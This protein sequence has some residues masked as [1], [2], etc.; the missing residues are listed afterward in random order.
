[1]TI[2]S[3]LEAAR[4][5]FD[6]GNYSDA[7]YRYEKIIAER[8][9]LAD[10]YQFNLRCARARS[11]IA[12]A[13]ATS[14]H[15]EPHR[16]HAS[17]VTLKDLYHQ[18]D[19]AAYS[20][21]RVEAA[22]V[23]LVSVLMTAHNVA[24]YI[25]DAVISVLR[26]SWPSLEVI[27]VDDASTDATWHVLQRLCEQEMRLKCVRL[28]TNLG[29]YFAKNL[30]L[31]ESSGRY[32]FFQDGDDLS[33]PERISMGMLHLLRPGVFAVRGAYSRVSFP[34]EE[35][36]PV[37]GL[38]S[39]LGLITIGVPRSVFDDIGYFNCTIK[40]SD[41][42][43]F[44]RLRC[45]ALN[46]GQIVA[47][48]SAPTY[49]NTFRPGSLFFDMIANDPGVD[50]VI[51]QRLSPERSAY[52]AAFK[53]KHQELGVEKFK[54]YF[55]FPVLRDLIPVQSGM[56]RLPNPSCP[57]VVSV[58]SVPEREKLLYRTL[59][60]LTGQ[61]DEIHVYLDR[62]HETPDF[63]RN[64]HHNVHVVSSAEQ[65]GLR[66]NGKFLPLSR[67]RECYFFTVDDDIIYPADYIAT[68]IQRIEFY[69]CKAVL[70]VHGVL[71]PEQARLYYSGYRRVFSFKRAL[72]RDALVNNLGTGTVGCHISALIGLG[73][74]HFSIPGMADLH[75]SI[76]CKQ[77]SIPMIALARHANWLIEQETSNISIYQEFY[78][79]DQAQS[80]LVAEHRPWGYAAIDQAVHAL[81]ASAELKERFQSLMPV[82]QAS[83]R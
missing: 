78:K 45:A 81:Q 19:I 33:H 1:M 22:S 44:E 59:E 51:E 7:V 18:V 26:Q 20:L 4:A 16:S 17:S 9:D 30:A 37:N 10:I 64:C 53:A 27:V 71:L 77:H 69:G 31:R 36:L 5:A 54:D 41:E 46:K 68:M 14:Q 62:Y 80:V 56:S 70:G 35:V 52:A 39:K 21:P 67:L 72:E 47:E 29:T 3:Q 11:A 13:E 49:Y 8:P 82:L 38:I 63:V 83:M 75:L 60:S 32:I 23:P 61:V 76:F 48:T 34:T 66:D 65:P 74:E 28:N 12:N 55:R 6:A 15:E 25:E 42:E 24:P 50:G 43:W 2:N 79:T 57:V 73:L 40:A 58:C